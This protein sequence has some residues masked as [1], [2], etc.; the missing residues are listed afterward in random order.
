MQ[1]KGIYGRRKI[2]IL[3]VGCLIFTLA[4]VSIFTIFQHRVNERFQSA[5]TS[6]LEKNTKK[7]TAY[8][9]S[10]VSDLQQLLGMLAHACGLLSHSESVRAGELAGEFSWQ[11]VQK[12]NI[13]ITNP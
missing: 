1:K 8:A 3:S 9:E 11:M 6:G 10:A 4:V 5:L 12:E 13:V 2:F 7:Q